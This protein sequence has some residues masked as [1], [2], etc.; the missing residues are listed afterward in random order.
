MRPS[1]KWL[2]RFACKP[3]IIRA[4]APQAQGW[5]PFS[6]RFSGGRIYF[7][8]IE[9]YDNITPYKLG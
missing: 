2:V 3:Q 6:S 8:N 1:A 9:P 7:E 5:N 4:D